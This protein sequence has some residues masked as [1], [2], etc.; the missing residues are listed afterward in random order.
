MIDEKIYR[1]RIKCMASP[2]HLTSVLY[3]KMYKNLVRV[4]FFLNVSSFE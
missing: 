1:K 3:K 2:I 4:A